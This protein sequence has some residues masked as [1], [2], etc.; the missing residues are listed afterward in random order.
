MQDSM[1]LLY[2]NIYTIKKSQNIRYKQDVYLGRS[3]LTVYILTMFWIEREAE[4]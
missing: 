1:L 4:F 2:N 3:E